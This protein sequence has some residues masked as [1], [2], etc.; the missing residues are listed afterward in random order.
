MP[1]CLYINY[2]H[3]AEYEADKKAWQASLADVLLKTRHNTE[4]PSTELRDYKGKA[5]ICIYR[6]GSKIRDFVSRADSLFDWN[7][8]DKPEDLSFLTHGHC[9]MGMN[10]HEEYAFIDDN[11]ETRSILYHE[12]VEYT[13]IPPD[14][15]YFEAY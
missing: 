1:F 13:P 9:Y 14:V 2:N 5:D 12:Q 10:A 4:W 6:I 7:Y 11:K 8:P 3:D 15:P